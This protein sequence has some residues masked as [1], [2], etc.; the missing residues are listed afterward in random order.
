M[1]IEAYNQISQ[2]YGANKVRKTTQPQKTAA[3]SDSFQVS[4]FGKTLQTAKQ[5][6]SEAPDIRE[7]KVAPIREAIQ[8]G[9]YNVSSGDFASRLMEKLAGANTPV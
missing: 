3:A 5:A 1:R 8:N 9:T 6:V 4:S 7:E 2:I